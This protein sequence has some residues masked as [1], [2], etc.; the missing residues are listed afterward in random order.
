MPDAA[1]HFPDFPFSAA[2]VSPSQGADAKSCASDSKSLGRGAMEP[3]IDSDRFDQLVSGHLPAALAFA[4]RLTGDVHAAEDLVQEALYRAAKSWESFEGRSA[5]KTWLF[6]I[7]VNVFRDQLARQT[8]ASELSDDLAD[9]RSAGPVDRAS[10]RELGPLVARLVSALP[11][12]QRE[13]LV[14]TAYE[15]L[16]PAEA[17]G[18]LGI[19]ESNARA[20]LA[21]ARERLKRQLAPYVDV[22]QK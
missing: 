7:A 4:V 19:S 3:A 1:A 18:A 12:R 21:H 17:A 14:L 16:T 22:K 10:A 5:F 11:P 20:N 9:D 8:P 6:Q 2:G 15:G 13:V